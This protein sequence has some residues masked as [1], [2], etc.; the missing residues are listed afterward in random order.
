MKKRRCPRTYEVLISEKIPIYKCI[1]EVLISPPTLRRAAIYEVLIFSTTRS[2]GF[3]HEV[4]ISLLAGRR[5]LIHE[6]CISLRRAESPKR[7]Q[8]LVNRVTLGEAGGR[9]QMWFTF[10]KKQQDIENQIG[11]FLRKTLLFAGKEAGKTGLLPIRE[12]EIHKK[13]WKAIMLYSVYR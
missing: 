3:M 1:Y 12:V 6:V 4:L 8:N 2:G 5:E 13:Q 10:I 7:D 9:H 11:R